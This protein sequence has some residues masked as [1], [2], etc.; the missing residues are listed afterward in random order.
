HSFLIEKEGKGECASGLRSAEILNCSR[1]LAEA[2]AEADADL[3]FSSRSNR[4][5]QRGLLR[6]A[7]LRLPPYVGSPKDPIE[8][9]VREEELH[10]TKA[11]AF[12]ASAKVIYHSDSDK[13]HFGWPNIDE[14][15]STR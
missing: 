5:W 2:E 8:N 11:S 10:R 6:G 3:D 4:T 7:T 15:N 14:A 12:H 13:G 9:G 1:A